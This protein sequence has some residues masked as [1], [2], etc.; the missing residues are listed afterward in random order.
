MPEK[1]LR[2]ARIYDRPERKGPSP[3]LIALA[4][5][6]LLVVGYFVYHALRPGPPSPTPAHVGLLLIAG[7]AL[8][9]SP[10]SVEPGRS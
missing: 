9:A 6:I 2:K 4:L 5:L 8:V 1:P 3:L 7:K 10:W